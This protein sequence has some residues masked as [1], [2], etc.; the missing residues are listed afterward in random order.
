MY[1]S[2]DQ[3]VIGTKVGRAKHTRIMPGG[4][5]ESTSAD[6]TNIT[7][8]SSKSSKSSSSSPSSVFVG[9]KLDDHRG[10]FII[11]YPMDKGC[12]RDGEQNWEYME[13]LWN[14][15]VV[16]YVVSTVYGCMLFHKIIHVHFHHIMT[17]D[18]IIIS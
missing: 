12:V 17:Y 1:I 6:E 15:S 5:L 3:I 4:A 16:L 10:A 18:I 11:D 14:V 13:L 9:K 8:S 7:A 2:L